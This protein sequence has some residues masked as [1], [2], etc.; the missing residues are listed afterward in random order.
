[1]ILTID[2]EDLDEQAQALFDNICDIIEAAQVETGI[3]LGILVA[4]AIDTAQ[5]DNM[6]KND[7]IQGISAAWDTWAEHPV[8]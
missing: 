5:R 1:M 2:S 4:L 7:F 8:H 3:G 6:D